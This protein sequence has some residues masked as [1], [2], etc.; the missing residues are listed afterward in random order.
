MWA[1]SLLL[2]KFQEEVQGSEMFMTAKRS[3]QSGL[4]ASGVV[5]GWTIAAT[6]L[7]STSWVYE[8]GVSGA[9]FY[10]AYA[11]VQVFVFAIAAIE[12]KRRAPGAH[13]VLE[14][15]RVRYGKVGHT[16]QIFYSTLRQ[17]FNSVNIL[18]GGS[19]VFTALTG[20]NVIACIWTLP[21]GVAIY[22]M[23]G[24]IKATILTDYAHNIIVFV[25]ILTGMFVVYATSRLLGSPTAVF[26]ALQ[27]AAKRAPIAGNAGGGYL[28]M[29]SQTGILLGV[30][31]LTS[32]FGSTV[33]VQLFQKAIA[34][35]PKAT[36]PGYFIG[37][38][39]WLAIPLG[40][41][42]TFGLACR[43]I[44]NYP[45]FPTY[46][47]PM[48][49]LEISQGLAFP[50]AAETLMGKGGAGV[51]LLMT[52]MAC[53]SGFSAD[54]V[55]VA[56]VFT[57]DVYA[58]YIDKH[59]GGARV[60]TISHMTVV[61]WT[62]C[63][64]AIA[65][66]LSQ[67]TIGVSYM[68]TTTGIFTA[69]MVFPM[70][71]TVMWKHQN[72]AAAIAAPI[73]GSITAIASWLGSAYAL[74]GTITVDSTSAVLPLVIGNSVSLVSG[75]VYSVLLTL[76]FGSQQF[77]WSLLKTEICAIDDSDVK[78][79]TS[80]QFMQQI[81]SE[82]LSIDDERA[83]LH[84][85]KVGIVLA[86]TL[87]LTLVVLF[88]L[89]LYGTGYVFSR[90]FFTF[91]VVLTFLVAWSSALVILL[92]PVWQGRHTLK[93]FLWHAMGKRGNKLSST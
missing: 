75:A 55:S 38:L 28:T 60:V 66:G 92:L 24:G 80:E 61:V 81:G 56:S 68:L 21:V 82:K 84:A 77:D 54:L 73:L 31:V 50:Y 89:S 52:F 41:A 29:S 20:M 10:G 70:Y 33:D 69:S 19:A 53:T 39:A 71:C 17:I 65:T 74:E 27:E 2:A 85:R 30:V 87:F 32:A 22:T 5:S 14:V 59:V 35:S 79:V 37:G 62:V 42:T 18:I 76:K 48:S 51:V 40:L 11:N 7:T 49:E 8:F 72:V 86:A 90:H 6:L 34:A 88:P 43:A 63:I 46:P 47:R 67:T 58:A 57:Y 25:L 26:E 4:V 23:A 3:I 36:L 13:T 15:T 64:A 9:Y 93:L 1:V 16:V 78:G 83:L 91:W 44:E 45:S 12:L